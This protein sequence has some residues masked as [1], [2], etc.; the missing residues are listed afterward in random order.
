[1]TTRRDPLHATLNRRQFLGRLG[2]AVGAG[3]AGRGL[4]AVGKENEQPSFAEALDFLDKEFKA[5]TF[6]GAALVVTQHRK[7][8]LEKYWGTYTTWQKPDIPCGAG[9]VNMLY[10]VS[11]LVTSTVV[12][13]AH[14]DGLLDYDAPV[15]KYIPE[16]VGGGKDKIIVR[17]LLTHA[18]GIPG[19]PLKAVDTEEKWQAA[20]QTLCA[21]K[22]DWEPGSRTVYHGLTGHLLAA[23]IVRRGSGRK[24][25][26]TICRE[27]LFG[28]LGADS[29]T[30]RVPAKD[31]PVAVTPRS[32]QEALQQGSWGIAGHPAGGAFGTS[33][34]L[35]KVLHL[36]LNQGVWQG[37]TL[38]KPDVLKE[39]HTVQ[40]AA[41]IEKAIRAG[42]KPGYQTWGLGVLLRGTGPADGAHDWFGMGQVKTP[43]VFGHAGISTIIGVA[44]PDRDAA[45]VFLTTDAPKPDAKVGPLRS[46][47]VAKVLAKLA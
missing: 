46:G 39:M 32:F 22:V 11:K 38:I 16:F 7:T 1:M 40:Y 24:S 10:S 4:P 33:A 36:H 20:I 25:W 29:L 35:L 34:D 18:A 30:F 19:V 23:E 21:A 28:P 17:H 15:S 9:M 26:D 41:Q 43:A 27:R 6:P 44:D 8:V 31:V 47:V 5:A 13:I 45:L 37:K 12:V 42:Q 2:L 14:Q 3:I